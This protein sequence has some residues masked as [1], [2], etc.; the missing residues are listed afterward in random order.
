MKLIKESNGLK[1]ATNTINPVEL[2]SKTSIFESKKPISTTCG[3]VVATM[4]QSS[5]ETVRMALARKDFSPIRAAGKISRNGKAIHKGANPVPTYPPI[6]EMNAVSNRA[7][8]HNTKYKPLAKTILVLEIPTPFTSRAY[9]PIG[10]A[11][12]TDRGV[13]PIVRKNP[14]E[15]FAVRSEMGKNRSRGPSRITNKKRNSNNKGNDNNKGELHL[16][17]VA[18]G[19]AGWGFDGFWGGEF[20]WVALELVDAVDEGGAVD[21][22]G[23]VG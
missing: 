7:G 13:V 1:T 5:K 9:E 4:S 22:F 23:G 21:G 15:Q 11:A 10:L 14:I 17:V 8:S 16:L 12:S 19:H 6:N 20:G 18:D 3:Q 2:R